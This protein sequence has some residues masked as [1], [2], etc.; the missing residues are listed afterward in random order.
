MTFRYIEQTYKT[1]KLK[2]G[3]ILKYQGE[4]CRL[5]SAPDQYLRVERL[6]DG[7]RLILHPMWEVEYP[8]D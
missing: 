2:R 4:D 6:K 8:E 7:R 3:L 1:P 5:L